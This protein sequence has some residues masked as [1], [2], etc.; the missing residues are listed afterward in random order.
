MNILGINISHNASIALYSDGKIK[1][2][3]EEDRFN[4]IK[5]WHPIPELGIK[6]GV[7]NN[8]Y[9][10]FKKI[11]DTIDY[12]IYS[13]FRNKYESQFIINTIQ[14][15]LN[16]PRYYFNENNHHIYHA[17]SGYHFSKFDEAICIVVDGG[18][19][20]P[21]NTFH[22][23]IE[24]IF[25]IDRNKIETYYQ[26]LSNFKYDPNR[27]GVL[28][29]N[30]QEKIVKDNTEYLL[31]NTNGSGNFFS[32]ACEISGLNSLDAGKLMGLSC[33]SVHD[34]RFSTLSLKLAKVAQEYLYDNIVSLIEKAIDKYPV[35]NIVLSGGCALNCLNNFKYVKK[36]TNLNFFIDP[37][38]H[39]GG[40]SIGA[41]IYYNDYYKS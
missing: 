32:L 39:D 35:K 41:A 33:Y 34:K 7:L 37:V 15:Q 6:N 29:K 17:V 1:Q 18:G 5:N 26:H 11:N 10:S 22:H 8:T 2:Y 25:F 19:S 40:T 28:T 30:T 38:P 31:S 4:K 27:Y 20:S 13:S 23:E 21:F 9:Q 36:F 3:Y 16:N 12:V 24:S 14:N